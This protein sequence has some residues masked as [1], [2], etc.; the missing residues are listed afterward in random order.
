[1]PLSS[2][3]SS[4]LILLTMRCT[5]GTMTF[6]VLFCTNEPAR[7]FDDFSTIRSPQVLSQRFVGETKRSLSACTSSGDSGLLRRDILS[8]INTRFDA[9]PCRI[10]FVRLVQRYRQYCL[11][12]SEY[13]HLYMAAVQTRGV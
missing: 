3:R 5:A 6:V 8:G 4:M 10:F 7:S 11:P 1:M 12:S 13:N 2:V 9:R